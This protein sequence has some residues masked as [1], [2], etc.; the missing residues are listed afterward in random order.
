MNYV[1]RSAFAA[2]LPEAVVP[3]T[4]PIAAIPTLPPD[5]TDLRPERLD[6]VDTASIGAR[7]DWVQCQS[8]DLSRP[9]LSGLCAVQAP[10]GRVLKLRRAICTFPKPPTNNSWLLNHQH[11]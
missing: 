5:S 2:F 11:R 8:P 9:P 10:D 6:F 7:V 3:Q 4:A 1:G